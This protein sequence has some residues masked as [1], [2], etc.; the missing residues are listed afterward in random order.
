MKKNHRIVLIIE[1]L[2]IVCIIL[3]LIE[4]SYMDMLSLFV[5]IIIDI[6][7]FCSPLAYC[8]HI[9][10]YKKTG[11]MFFKKYPYYI[12]FFI[13]FLTAPYYGIIYIIKKLKNEK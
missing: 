4:V 13:F 9:D 10:S 2:L 8:Y 6:I 3:S 11:N 1:I 7:L 5:F 12:V